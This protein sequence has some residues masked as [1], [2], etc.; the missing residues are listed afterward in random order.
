MVDRCICRSI[1]F[2][3]I[4]AISCGEKDIEKVKEMVLCADKCKMC[5]PYI[6]KALL[7][8]E[9]EFKPNKLV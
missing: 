4:L 6:K 1:S 3:E 5:E 7:T 2:A 9:K 8:G